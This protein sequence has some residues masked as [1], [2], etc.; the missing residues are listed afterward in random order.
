VDDGET[1][2]PGE[3]GELLVRGAPVIRGYLNRPEATAETIVDGWLH[4]GDIAYIDEDGFIYIVDRAKDMV[5]RG[6]ENVYCAEVENA[7]FSHDAVAECVVFAV[8]DERLGEEVGAAVY[9]KPG[10]SSMR[11]PRRCASTARRCCRR[12]RCRATSGSWTSPCRA[13]PTASSS[14]AS[15]RIPSLSR[16]RCLQASSRLSSDDRARQ[17]GGKQRACEALRA[18]R[19]GGRQRGQRRTQYAQLQLGSLVQGARRGL[20]GMPRP[21]A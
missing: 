12:T 21:S 20:P 14:S 11:M 18:S 16:G 6:G 19:P 9:L 15:C 13:T 1:L 7:I 17:A 2:G 5:L 8:P 10:R 3:I 4:T